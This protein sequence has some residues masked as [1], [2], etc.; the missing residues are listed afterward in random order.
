MSDTE[1]TYLLLV[2]SLNREKELTRL[3][4]EQQIIN[5]SLQLQIEMERRKTEVRGKNVETVFLFLKELLWSF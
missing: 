4:N 3:L 1:E 2:E 5:D